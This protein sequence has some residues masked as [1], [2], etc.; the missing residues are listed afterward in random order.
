M[1]KNLSHNILCPAASIDIPVSSTSGSSNSIPDNSTMMINPSGEGAARRQQVQQD[2]F[3][4]QAEII[5]TGIHRSERC[6]VGLVTV[7]SEIFGLKIC[8]DSPFL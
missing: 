4:L 8:T 3:N 2:S 7:L 5:E 6:L 1:P